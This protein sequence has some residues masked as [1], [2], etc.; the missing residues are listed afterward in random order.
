M[1]EFRIWSDEFV[2]NGFLSKQHEFDNQA[3]GVQGGNRSPALFWENPP[4]DTASFA[5]TLYDPDAPTGSGFWH[6]VVANLAPDVRT[7]PAGAGASSGSGLPA[8]AV[9]TLNDY[10]TAGFGGAAP[11]RGDQPHRYIFRVHALSKAM[12]PIDATTTNAVARFM[13]HLNEIDSTTVTGL[14]ELR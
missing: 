9:Q 6:W 14:Y 10:G 5:V 11:P 13:I 8:G 4:A 1:A 2:E 3:F 12:L 7:L